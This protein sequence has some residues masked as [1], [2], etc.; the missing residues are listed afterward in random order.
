MDGDK[1]A[2]KRFQAYPIAST[3]CSDRWR[4]QP[5][6]HI[7]LAEMRTEEGKLHLF[8]TVGQSSKVAFAR[9][10]KKASPVTATAFLTVL[11]DAVPYKI[12]HG[13]HR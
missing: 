3:G 12:S 6:F 2:E 9:L 10:E 1:P 7:D 11:V 8:V 4:S 5:R 13:A